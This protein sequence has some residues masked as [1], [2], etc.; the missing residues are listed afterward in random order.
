[1]SRGFYVHNL[2]CKVNRVESDT[3]ASQL[4]ESGIPMVS[5]NSAQVIILNTCTV[6]SEADAKTRKAIRQACALSTNPW[7][8]VTGCSTVI[9]AEELSRLGA[10]VIVEPDRARALQRAH[11]LLQHDET[12]K[13]PSS[14]SQN[15]TNKHD[16]VGHTGP[17]SQDAACVLHDAS[18]PSLGLITRTGPAFKTRVGIKIQDGCNNRCSYCIVSTVRGPSRSIP[19]DEIITE[20]QALEH[21]GVKEIVFTGINLG[22]YHDDAVDLVNLL[23]RCLRTV[24]SARIRLSSIEPMDVTDKLLD[25]MVSYQGHICAHLHMPLQSGSD[26][27]LRLMQR[28]Y[29]TAQYE[30]IIHKARAALPHMAFTTDVIV[31]FPGETDEDFSKTMDFCTRV[32][33]AKLHVFRYSKRQG[34]AAAQM[35][36]Q[37]PA[38]VKSSRSAQLRCLSDHL[39]N[40]AASQRVGRTE[41]VLVERVGTG[42]SESYHTVRLSSTFTPGSLV[43][44]C[45][46]GNDGPV[47][48]SQD[49]CVPVNKT[50]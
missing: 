20:L 18:V 24:S 17:V 47:L 42:T 46:T 11:S 49:M 50:E 35:T 21:A 30:T 38:Q 33:F 9:H 1:M 10:Q 16:K 23:K 39:G 41:L 22:A 14:S 40:E 27:I 2:G 3:I 32:G 25:L 15:D 44:L 13:C 36:E 5:R 28:P 4:I 6:T 29:T 12:A 48:I 8:V 45:I 31:G 37:V 34:T 19:Q 43:S 7:V 26:R